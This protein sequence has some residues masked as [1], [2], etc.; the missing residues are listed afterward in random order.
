MVAGDGEPRTLQPF[1]ERARLTKLVRFRS[2]GEITRDDDEIGAT[3]VRQR[4][5]SLGGV[6]AMRPTEVDVGEMEQPRR[7]DVLDRAQT[8]SRPMYSLMPSVIVSTA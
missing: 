5:E 1:D 2:L 7:R 4:Q 6:E 3:L 8:R